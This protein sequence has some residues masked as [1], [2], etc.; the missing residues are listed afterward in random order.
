MRAAGLT[1]TTDLIAAF[2]TLT[3]AGTTM[4]QQII[5]L[6]AYGLQATTRSVTSSCPTAAMLKRAAT[7]AG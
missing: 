4:Q 5:L 1:L 7:T 3:S 6:S 2:A